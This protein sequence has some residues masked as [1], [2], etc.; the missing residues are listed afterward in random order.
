MP[1]IPDNPMFNMR[2]S[3]LIYGARYD[4]TMNAFGGKGFFVEDPKDLKGV[5]ADAVNFRGPAGQR[6]DPAGLR[7]EAAAIPLAQLIC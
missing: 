2:P 6:R 3:M 7:Q 1:E 4:R 5:L